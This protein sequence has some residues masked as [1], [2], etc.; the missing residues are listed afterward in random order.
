MWSNVTI[1]K[2]GINIPYSED[3]TLGRSYMMQSNTTTPTQTRAYYWI[4]KFGC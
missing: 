4:K 3:K 2:Y 1:T